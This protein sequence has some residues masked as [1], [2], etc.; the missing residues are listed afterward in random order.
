[1]P[2]VTPI[3]QPIARAFAEAVTSLRRDIVRSIGPADLAHLKRMERWG[4][5]CTVIGYAAAPFFPNPL[6]A[7]G[8]S[9]GNVTRW[10]LMHHISH[11]GYDKVPGVPARYTSAKFAQNWRRF[12]DW[13]DWILPAAWSYEHNTLHHYHTGE[14]RDPDLVER[15]I[16]DGRMFQKARWVRY[17]LVAFFA[18]TW[19]ISYY[20]P[21]TFMSIYNKQ[22]APQ[23][24]PPMTDWWPFFNPFWSHGRAFWRRCILPYGL[25]RFV[26]IP[27]LALPISRWASLCVLINSVLAEIVTNVHT[28]A[29]IA[30]NHAGDD[31]YRFDT[32]G[33]D[34]AEYYARQVMG[35]ANYACGSDLLDF[36]Q[37]WLNYQIEHHVWPDLPMLQYQRW[38]PQLQALCVKH[39]LPYV[40]E[41][42]FKRNRR[43]I[44]VMV[45]KT[46]MQR[47][48]HLIQRP[49]VQRASAPGF[50]VITALPALSPPP[51]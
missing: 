26:M 37:M 13:F 48:P 8:I 16:A 2:A 4:R 29:V 14:E 25:V 10:L 6:A 50:P 38:Q 35:S 40:Q 1:M 11:R 18:M 39:G 31:L 45:G 7:W 42:V 21:N 47:V 36:S 5:F 30:P 9:Q 23:G 33:K 20:A 32:P 49:V 24:Q 44:D 41:S 12:V 51:T 19:K 34:K 15:N 3:P 27:A 43:L 28:F 46:S 22:H 17:L